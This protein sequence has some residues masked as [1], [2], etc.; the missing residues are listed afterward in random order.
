MSILQDPALLNPKRLLTSDSQQCPHCEVNLRV[1]EV[2]PVRISSRFDE[3]TTLAWECLFCY[4]ADV[5]PGMEAKWA[6]FV[7]NY[8]EI[9]E[10]INASKDDEREA[11]AQGLADEPYPGCYE[12]YKDQK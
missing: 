9:W 12:A 1:L 3:A 6:E 4:K 8:E 5:I 2:Q 11:Y 7:K 10:H